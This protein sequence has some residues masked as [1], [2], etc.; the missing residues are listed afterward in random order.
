[1]PASEFKTNCILSSL[2]AKAKESASPW[3]S[4]VAVKLVDWPSPLRFKAEN[5]LFSMPGA[6]VEPARRLPSRGF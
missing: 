4:N 2:S 6:G 1:M 3:L 5:P